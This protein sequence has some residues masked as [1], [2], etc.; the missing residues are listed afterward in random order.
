MKS[1]R[2]SNVTATIIKN[3]APHKERE[4]MDKL[5]YASATALAQSIRAKEISSEEVVDAYLQRIEEAN[6]QLNAVVQ[7][8]ADAARAQAREAD[9][10]L[11]KGHIRGPL[12]GVPMTIKDNIETT[13]VICTGGTK[14]R[15]SYV[16]KQDA[17]VVA[18]MHDAG[19]IMLGKTNLPE[20]GL[21]FETDN[22]VYGR[23]NNPYDLSCTPGGSSGGEAA[24]IAAGGSPLGLGNDMGGSIR[25]SAHFCGIAGIKPTTGRVPRTGHFPWP[26]NWLDMLWQPGPMARFV[27]DLVLVLPIIV[28]VDWRDPSV[29]P[30][31]FGDP[32]MV[33]LKSLRVAFHIDNGIMSPSRE[34]VEVVKKTAKVLSEADM[35]VEEDLPSG[36]EQS[37][38]IFF[39]LLAAD[40][41]A[42]METLLHMVG[43]TEMH[44]W[45][46]GLLE[47]CR[48]TAMT[49]A[50]FTRL[51]LKWAMFRSS[52]L[53]FM[54]KYDVIICPVCA[55][56][57]PP[58]GGTLAAD[59][60]PAFSYTMTYNLTGWPSVVVRGGT[61]PE[62]LPIGVQVVARPWREDIALAVAQ[63]IETIL[64]GWQRP[65]L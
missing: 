7:L 64:G 48:A 58:H 2:K 57:A 55:Y 16:P 23:T 41:G 3:M 21:T 5:T 50:D 22:L 42:G 27:E 61:S 1:L 56:A 63:N 35:A 36:I 65:P 59:R 14:G 37:Y 34:I 18:R 44:P 29:V 15:A 25:L 49:T 10:A 62:G 45:T 17:T 4:D 28:G 6:P 60:I 33:N 40:G 52:M 19:A 32:R 24:I 47:V 9:A 46:N 30:M 31:P 53:S 20:L 12:H 43:T 39:G 38:E 11:A 8:T 26:G 54:R 13:G 51:M